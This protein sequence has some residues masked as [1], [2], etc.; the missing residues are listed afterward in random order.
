MCNVPIPAETIVA[1]Q[2]TKMRRL[3]YSRGLAKYKLVEVEDTPAAERRS[4][5]ISKK[6]KQG[7]P[8]ADAGEIACPFPECEQ[9]IVPGYIHCF[10]CG[11]LATYE[12]GNAK[13]QVAGGSGGGSSATGPQR[14]ESGGP[15]RATGLSLPSSSSSHPSTTAKSG[16]L[17]GPD[18]MRLSKEDKKI[19]YGDRERDAAWKTVRENL[20]KCQRYV[21]TIQKN[22]AATFKKNDN[23]TLDP[24]ADPE[25]VAM[26][27]EKRKLCHEL[28]TFG[29]WF[30]KVTSDGA[31]E[32]EKA[33]ARRSLCRLYFAERPPNRPA[34]VM[35]DET[36]RSSSESPPVDRK[37][38]GT[39]GAA[40]SSDWLA[41]R[42]PHESGTE[43][44]SATKKRNR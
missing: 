9:V 33:E 14:I 19:V 42:S 28:L 40:S 27:F 31:S 16:S 43:S 22:P 5:F 35:K 4:V 17:A 36:G 37:R 44:G 32:Q 1:V 41:Y 25:T 38:K 24:N 6:D 29:G 10:G 11:R 3:V 2:D 13:E 7:R 30:A 23:F 26:S 34:E 8:N 20:K 21:N 15:S 18:L 39:T 12:I